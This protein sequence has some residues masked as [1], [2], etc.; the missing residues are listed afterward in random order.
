MW[1]TRS[2]EELEVALRAQERALVLDNAAEP[3]AHLLFLL[4][5]SLV[6]C[7]RLRVLAKADERVAQVGLT[8]E[9]G[10]SQA[11]KWATLEAARSSS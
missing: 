8:E 4:R 10:W 2:C 7:N 3:S 1:H 9:P 11:V 5:L 6:E